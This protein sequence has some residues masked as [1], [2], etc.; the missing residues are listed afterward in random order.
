MVKL[1]P[2]DRINVR[3]TS[4]DTH[5][6]TPDYIKGKSGRV[7]ALCGTFPNPESLAYGLDGRPSKALYRVEFEMKE[8][9]GEQYAGPEGDSLLVDVYEQWLLPA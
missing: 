2:G 9:W 1:N 5:H 7:Q 8:L 3:S 6:R 4:I